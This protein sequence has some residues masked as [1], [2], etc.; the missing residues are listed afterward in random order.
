M[1]K[2]KFIFIVHHLVR[3]LALFIKDDEQGD[4]QKDNDW[5]NILEKIH[6]LFLQT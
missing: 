5:N 1:K 3:H 4:K 2:N 6:F